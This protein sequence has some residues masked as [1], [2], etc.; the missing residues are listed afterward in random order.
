MREGD[1]TRV[2]ATEALPIGYL[3]EVTDA[4]TA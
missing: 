4:P 1:T 2:I 3:A